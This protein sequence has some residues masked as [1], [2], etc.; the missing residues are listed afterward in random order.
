MDTRRRGDKLRREADLVETDAAQTRKDAEGLGGLVDMAVDA[1]DDAVKYA[2]DILNEILN[3]KE[4]QDLENMLRE[5][6]QMLEELKD[7]EFTQ[8]AEDAEMELDK[9]I[10]GGC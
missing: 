8:A 6:E 5:A 7:R 1:G 9:A 3:S 10:D 4:S 2:Q